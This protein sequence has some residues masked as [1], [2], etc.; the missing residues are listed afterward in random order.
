MLNVRLSFEPVSIQIFLS[1]S[2]E[3]AAIYR[4]YSERFFSQ[5]WKKAAT[6]DFLRRYSF[7]GFAQPQ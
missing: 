7:V 4:A 3:N 1:F 6:A 5:V 2:L